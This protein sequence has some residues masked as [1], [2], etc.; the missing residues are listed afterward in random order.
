MACQHITGD[1]THQS[2]FGSARPALI[3]TDILQETLLVM[4]TLPFKV[5]SKSICKS[6]TEYPL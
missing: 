4:Y 6:L 2:A 1:I 5:R 3:K